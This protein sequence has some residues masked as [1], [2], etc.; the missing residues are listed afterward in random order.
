[1]FLKS[2]TMQGFKSFANKTTIELNESITAIVGPN[3]SGKSNITDAITWVLGETSVKNLRGSK[4]EDVI[5]SGTD[6]KKPLGMAE[7][8]IVFDN[9]D[10]TLDTPYNEVA[11]TRRM[12]RSLE[13]EFLINNK[14]CR[15]KDIK[16]L[17]MDTGIGKDGYSVIGQGKIE[18]VLSSRPEDRRAIFEEA[19][20]ISK[21]K[22]KKVQSKNKLL[23]T[24]ENLIRIEDLLSEISKQEESLRR[25]S[26]KATKYL[27][28]YNKLKEIDLNFVSKK[29]FE[30]NEDVEKF[31]TLIAKLEDELLS[32]QK[33]R[34]DF[35][36]K[37]TEIE[38]LIDENTKELSEKKEELSSKS[39]TLEKLKV[40]SSV[41]DEQIKSLNRDLERMQDEEVERRNNIDKFE[42]DLDSLLNKK[43]SLN[44]ERDALLE[45]I[46]E[47][48]SIIE[49]KSSE[50]NQI[51]KSEKEKSSNQNLISNEIQNI[52]FKN[53]TLSTMIEDKNNRRASIEDNIANF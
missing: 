51:E 16:E 18:S 39:E 40:K 36:S 9:T 37:K 42:E 15:L 7:V 44:E 20:G 26:Q 48:K 38:L 22:Y 41:L 49:I 2:I 52:K 30:L 27:E 43:N 53:E 8:T 1:M 19:A 45:K 12:Y 46:K 47:I 33:S 5:F 13:S 31:K 3:G 32:L 23:K 34:D 28:D 50:I 24:E 21:F 4:M 11:V 14:K 10:R 29:I 35:S 6:S 17:F 25:Q